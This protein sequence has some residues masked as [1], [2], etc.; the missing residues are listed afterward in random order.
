MSK[1]SRPKI[2]QFEASTGETIVRYMNDD[3]FAQYQQDQ[4]EF[5]ARKAAE[6]AKIA[7]RIAILERLGLTEDEAKLILN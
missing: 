5:Q 1:I 4:A 6:E 3:E 2:T 7:Q